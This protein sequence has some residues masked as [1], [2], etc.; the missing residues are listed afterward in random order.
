MTTEV[1][2]PAELEAF[3]QRCVRTGRY[4]SMDDVIGEALRLLQDR[5]RRRQEFTEMLD[6]VRRE[7]ETRGSYDLDDVLRDL[8]AL[9]DSA[10]R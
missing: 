1:D 5:E 8:D 7:T 9:I 10:G 6:A 3:A 2:L 4:R